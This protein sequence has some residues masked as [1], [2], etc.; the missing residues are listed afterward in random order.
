MPLCGEYKGTS[1][2]MQY[3]DRSGVLQFPMERFGAVESHNFR[4]TTG[5][6][7]KSKQ[8]QRKNRKRAEGKDGGGEV[9][10][11]II[12]FYTYQSVGFGKNLVFFSKVG[13]T[14]NRPVGSPSLYSLFR[15]P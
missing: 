2:C 12:K 13:R 1:R 4:Q 11:I 7:L 3:S 8:Q 9:K 10:Y 5:S 6:L 14:S 15:C